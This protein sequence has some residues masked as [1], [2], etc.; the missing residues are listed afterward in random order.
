VVAGPEQSNLREMDHQSIPTRLAR[1]RTT[2]SVGL[3][4]EEQ[5]QAER[6]RSRPKSETGHVHQ[7]DDTVGPLCVRPVSR[8]KE[9]KSQRIGDAAIRRR[10]RPMLHR[11]KLAPVACAPVDRAWV[12]MVRGCC[13]RMIS[14]LDRIW[15]WVVLT[16]SSALA[17][18]CHWLLAEQP[19]PRCE[20]TRQVLTMPRSIEPC[21]VDALTG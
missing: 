3:A 11:W 4:G 5:T 19:D 9:A 10:M 18:R 12:D 8:K 21:L 6:H 15:V 14:L 2:S 16:P 7:S 17:R 1:F 13:V 20:T